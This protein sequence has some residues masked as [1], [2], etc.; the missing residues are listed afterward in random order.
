MTEGN[1]RLKEIAQRIRHDIDGGAAPHSEKVTVRKFLSWFGC[2][3]RGRSVVSEIRRMLDEHKLRTVP[4][5]EVTWIDALISVEHDPEVGDGVTA[6]EEQID[7]TVRVGAIE[8]ANRKPTS[9]NPHNPLRVATTLMLTN[10]FSQLPVMD[11]ERSVKGMIS[12]QSIGTRL[13]LGH[14]CPTVRHCMV[15]EIPIIPISEPLSSAIGNISRQGYVLVKGSDNRITGI[16]TASDVTHQFMQLAG[17]FLNVGEIEGYLRILI[18]HK[19]QIV[20]MQKALSDTPGRAHS[21]SRPADLTLGDYCKLLEQE[22]LWNKLN[23]NLDRKEFVKKLDWVRQIRNDVMHFDPDGIAPEDTKKLEDLAKFFRDMR[24]I[25][26][27]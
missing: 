24:H 22:D 3:R 15:P 13:S 5:F 12:W 7:P 14:P 26:A 17:P 21:V 11:G 16:V 10:D 6:S 23:L 2:S 25:T 9:V 8:A 27:I 19:F 18:H 4:D 1:E 20:E